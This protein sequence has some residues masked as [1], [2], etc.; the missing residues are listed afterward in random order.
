MRT[1]FDKFGV[2]WNQRYGNDDLELPVPA[3]FL[4]DK[5]GIVRNSFLDPEYHPRLD[6]ET[7]L[8]WIDQL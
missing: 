2:D 3:T 5:K 1:V 6:P 4:V 8:Q 7:A